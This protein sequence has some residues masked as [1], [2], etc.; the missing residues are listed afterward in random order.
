MRPFWKLHCSFKP[1][2]PDKV[3]WLRARRKSLTATATSVPTSF[4]RQRLP[5]R[6]TVTGS[7]CCSC[8]TKGCSKMVS[9]ASG[10]A[11]SMKNVE[12]SVS[13]V[14][15]L[16]PRVFRDDRGFFLESFSEKVMEELGIPQRFVQ[17]NHS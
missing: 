10:K 5:C 7:T 8:F 4:R 1:S 2:R 14:V 17:D 3:S 16:Q 9:V 6:T 15:V 11:F 13:G 12:T